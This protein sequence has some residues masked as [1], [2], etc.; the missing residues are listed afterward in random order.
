VSAN[1]QRCAKRLLAVVPTL[2]QELRVAMRAGRSSDLSVP[3]FRI[4]VFFQIHPGAP[5]T[6]AAEHLGLGLPATSKLADGLT[7]RGLLARETCAEDR[8]RKAVSITGAGLRHLTAARAAAMD[9][10]TQRLA[11][12]SDTEQ[13]VLFAV[14]GSLSRGFGI[15]EVDDDDANDTPDAPPRTLL[16]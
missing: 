14:L 12:L 9:A 15:P 1:A 6:Q 5:L 11:A 3:Q 7:A 4:L 10:F 13:D 16:A 2:M 8:R